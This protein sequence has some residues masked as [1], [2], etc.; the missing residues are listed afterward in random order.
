MLRPNH[1]VS[2]R[3]SGAPTGFAASARNAQNPVEASGR[4]PGDSAYTEFCATRYKSAGLR[5]GRA[6]CGLVMGPAYRGA[7]SMVEYRYE[8]RRGEEVLATG[9]LSWERPLEVGERLVLGG[10]PGIVRS[11]DPVLGERELRLVVQLWRE[12]A[13]R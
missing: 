1:D 5:T 6:G 2:A 7:G 10:R 11:I 8:L 3:A 12:D 4:P 13:D 9:H